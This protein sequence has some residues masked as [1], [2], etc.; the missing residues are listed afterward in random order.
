MYSLSQVHIHVCP[1]RFHI[2]VLLCILDSLGVFV[3]SWSPMNLY[4]LSCIQNLLSI[5]SFHLF[6]LEWGSTYFG[7]LRAKLIGGPL[8]IPKWLWPSMNWYK[9][10]L[11]FKSPHYLQGCTKNL[12]NME[13]LVCKTINSRPKVM[14]NLRINSNTVYCTVSNWGLCSSRVFFMHCY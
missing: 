6:E 9:N 12:L 3:G 13:G 11:L 14:L 2:R 5:I 7:S 8:G 4:L 10:V 1:I